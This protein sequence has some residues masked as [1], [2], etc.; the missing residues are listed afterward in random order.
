MFNKSKIIQLLFVAVSVVLVSVYISIQQ[1]TISKYKSENKRQKSNIEVLNQNIS[2]F[3]VDDSLNAA[4]IS[5]LNYTVSELKKYN[6]EHVD[7]IKKLKI[8]L[9]DVSSASSISTSRKDTIKVPLFI[10]DS[11]T[12]CFD[13]KSTYSDISGCIFGLDSVSINS[14]TRLDLSVFAYT[15]YSKKFL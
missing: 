7:E 6:K 1:S 11:S 9:K 8:R 2:Q 12:I 15:S 4:K 13:Y 3:I 10:K 14:D 5:S